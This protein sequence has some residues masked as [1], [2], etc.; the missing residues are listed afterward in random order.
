MY[1]HRWVYHEQQRPRGDASD[2]VEIA[3]GIVGKRFI[4]TGADRKR[5]RR[6]HDR[7]TVGCRVCCEAGANSAGRTAAIVDDELLP[8]RSVELLPD[9]PSDDISAARRRERDYE[10]H[11]MG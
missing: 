3:R 1:R 11:R 5:G 2:R 4:K 10:A 8:E 9:D 7:V 6:Q